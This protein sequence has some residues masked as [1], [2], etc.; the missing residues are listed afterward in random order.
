[1]VGCA[2][3]ETPMAAPSQSALPEIT[4]TPSYQPTF[5][6]TL[7]YTPTFPSTTEAGVAVSTPHVSPY[8]KIMVVDVEIQ[9]LKT[10]PVQVK[11]VIR[12]IVSDQCQ[13]GYYSVENRM[14][15]NV[16]ITLYGIHPSENSCLQTNQNIE[17]VLQLGRDMPESERG[18]SPGDYVLTVNN[19]QTKFSIR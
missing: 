9:Y 13:Y 8:I 5:T 15:Q 6:S 7:L 16:K 17:Y 2:K 12:G 4:S 19:Y 18:F 14:E 1:L 10:N 3:N 11:L